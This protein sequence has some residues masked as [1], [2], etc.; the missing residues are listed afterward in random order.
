M[1]MI[2]EEEVRWTSG[3]CCHLRLASIGVLRIVFGELRE[4][5]STC[6]FIAA[7]VCGR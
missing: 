4:F 2:G 3:D 6:R 1:S 7:S 5:Q